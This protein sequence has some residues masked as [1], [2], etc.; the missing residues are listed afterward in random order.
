V[1]YNHNIRD[2][3]ESPAGWARD[4]NALL[5]KAQYAWQR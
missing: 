4:S 5:V 3:K 2:F 1:I